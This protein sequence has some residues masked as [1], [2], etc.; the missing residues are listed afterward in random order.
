MAFNI[1][2]LNK[3]KRDLDKVN[4]EKELARQTLKIEGQIS[5]GKKQISLM[6]ATQKKLV[7]AEIK[8]MNEG[9]KRCY[10]HWWSRDSKRVRATSAA[11]CNQ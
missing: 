3:A 6:E 11:T 8:G 10:P 7:Q 1:R 5:I 9:L 2:R 4:R